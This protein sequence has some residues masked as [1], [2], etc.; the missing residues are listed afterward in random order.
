ML[1]FVVMIDLPHPADATQWTAVVFVI[2]FN[3]IGYSW[4]D[5]V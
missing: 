5:V 3:F 4:V 1:I 2:C